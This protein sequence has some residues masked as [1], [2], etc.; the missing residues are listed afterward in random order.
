MS[1]GHEGKE[2]EEFTTV[3]RKKE[4]KK[5]QPTM[6][7]D[8][9]ASGGS[10]STSHHEPRSEADSYHY[11]CYL[12]N[13]VFDLTT[14]ELSGKQCKPANCPHAHNEDELKAGKTLCET[15]FDISKIKKRTGKGCSYGS[16]CR[17]AHS[18]EELRKGRKERS[19]RAMEN[20]A[21]RDAAKKA[22]EKADNE[23]KE[24]PTKRAESNR[25]QMAA[26]ENT[27]PGLDG[28]GSSSTISTSTGRTSVSTEAHVEEIPRLPFP[29]DAE[30]PLAPETDP[31]KWR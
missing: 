30:Q 24:T 17:F 8:A 29:M 5:K 3:N 26:V 21:K 2:E 7:H 12:C 18:H 23:V 6:R 11:K 14:A 22:D 25:A 27:T 16:Q 13:T 15:K 19:D 9:G 4:K 10:S 1:S 20:L 31:T 28:P